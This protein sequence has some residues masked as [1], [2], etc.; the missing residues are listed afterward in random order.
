LA[1]GPAH[2]DHA[3]HKVVLALLDGYGAIGRIEH[4][5]DTLGLLVPAAEALAEVR[6][7]FSRKGWGF[8]SE[9]DFN[10]ALA[11]RAV[12]PYRQRSKEDAERHRVAMRIQGRAKRAEWAERAA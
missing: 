11:S 3:S 5:K 1:K 2:P 4:A 9:A 12:A 10:A 6:S 8:L 7:S